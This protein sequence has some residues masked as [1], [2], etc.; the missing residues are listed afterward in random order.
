[1]R[2]DG[3]FLI[4]PTLVEMFDN[5]PSGARVAFDASGEPVDQDVREALASFVDDARNR[6]I[7]VRLVGVDLAGAR[8]G[9][10]H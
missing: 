4:K 2:R 9:G 7:E 5:I 8:P 10:G 3:T 1:L 6:D